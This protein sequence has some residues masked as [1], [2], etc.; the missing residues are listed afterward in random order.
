[1]THST[2][3]PIGAGLTLA[4]L[5][6]DVHPILH[7]L[8]ESEPVSWI[9]ALDAWLI[10]DRSLCIQVMR[11]SKTYTVDHPGFS[12]AQVVGPSMLS[13]DGMSHL[14]HRSPFK[15]PF[16]KSE[17]QRRF[18]DHVI[19]EINRL[20]DGFIAQEE[21][22]LRR[23]F[24]GPISVMTMIEALGMD[25]TPVRNVL[26]WYDTI[27]DAVTR[28]SAG[29]P[30]SKEGKAAYQ[31]LNENLLPVLK[32]DADSSLLAAA[33]GMAQGLT[34][35]QIISNAAILLFGGIETTEGMIANALYHLLANPKQLETVRADLSIMPAVIEE[36]LR[37]E[38]AATVIDRYTT[39]DVQLGDA[40]IREGELVRISLAGANR[41][42]KTFENPDE[43][44][45][46]RSNLKEHVT[47]AQGPHVCLGIHLARLEAIESVKQLLIRLPNL[48]PKAGKIIKP[49]GLIFRK[50]QSVLANWRNAGQ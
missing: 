21:A 10:T 13:L 24:A 17:V 26:S 37:M 34:D 49:T 11:D 27:V 9:P 6:N 36:S 23:D 25:E 14:K 12:T 45:P 16:R 18:N 48:A 42:P 5:E 2:Q 4:D 15:R 8:R 46:Y 41:D 35:E 28:V 43:F 31:A 29:E 38:P 1:M 39:A 47:F 40:Y 7:R 32:R 44:D 19:Q 20:I 30:V 22:E 3:F 50:P 33:S